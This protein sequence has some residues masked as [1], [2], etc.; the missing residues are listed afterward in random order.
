MNSFI[1][2]VFRLEG[3]VALVTGAGS[4]LGQSFALALARSGASVV[5]GARRADRLAETAA[6]ISDAGGVVE[7]VELDVTVP[8]SIGRSS[9]LRQFLACAC[10]RA[11]AGIP[12]PKLPL[13]N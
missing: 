10:M 1:N 11:S 9:I 12:L 5:I 7:T 6:M 2:N 13:C 3:R 8:D 4:G